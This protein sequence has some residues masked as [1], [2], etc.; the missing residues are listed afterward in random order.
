MLQ[1][2]TREEDAKSTGFHEEWRLQHQLLSTAD[3]PPGFQARKLVGELFSIS[4]LSDSAVLVDEVLG[5]QLQAC[6]PAAVALIR[7][8]VIASQPFRK[9][10]EPHEAVPD[11]PQQ[12]TGLMSFALLDRAHHRSACAGLPAGG[13]RSVS[14]LA[15]PM[16]LSARGRSLLR[17]SVNALTKQSTPLGILPLRWSQFVMKRGERIVANRFE[18]GH[19]AGSSKEMVAEGF[20]HSKITDDPGADAYGHGL[21][22]CRR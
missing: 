14:Q 4:P 18:V 2:S 6:V 16:L 8:I 9:P 10:S 20:R 15:G 1:I 7:T 3:P 5:E 21:Q 12:A 13:H 17:R 11:A 22:S 19:G